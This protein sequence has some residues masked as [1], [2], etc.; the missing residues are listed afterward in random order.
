MNHPRRQ[1]GLLT[2][3]S[4]AARAGRPLWL[5]RKPWHPELSGWGGLLLGLPMIAAFGFLVF[6]PAVELVIQAVRGG[7][8]NFSTLF[9]LDLHTV[10]VT[11][12]DSAL[13]S[14]ITLLLGSVVAW[15]LRTTK[16]RLLSALFW[17]AVVLPMAMSVVVKNYVWILM[18]GRFGVINAFLGALGFPPHTFL[19]TTTAVTIGM[20]YSLF[21]FAVFP[22]YIT[23][24]SIP[25]ELLHAS[26]SLGA[27]W[28]QTITRVVIPLSISGLFIT[29]VLLFVLSIGFFVTPVVLG[30]PK[31]TFL[32]ALIQQDIELRFDQAAAAAKAVFLIAVALALVL[33]LLRLVGRERFDRA[34]G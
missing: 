24:R 16:S 19:L 14:L 27:R 26:E 22:L 5:R 12:L 10:R 28:L 13:V 18:L 23:F 17:I 21:P 8:A 1:P 29:G 32:A 34:L 11:L 9:G 33:V 4:A 6:Y 3:N 30:G 31:S 2:L 7:S 20:V 15:T 25:D